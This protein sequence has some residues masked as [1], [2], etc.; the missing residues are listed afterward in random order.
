[1]ICRKCWIKVEAFHNYYIHIETIHKR[2][3]INV[4]EFMIIDYDDYGTTNKE[5]TETDESPPNRK[6]YKDKS[7]A[8]IDVFDDSNRSRKKHVKKNDQEPETIFQ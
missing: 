3:Q 5:Q 1:M 4:Q 7:F 8:E 2:R 6:T